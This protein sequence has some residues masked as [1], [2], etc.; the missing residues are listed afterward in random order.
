MNS[1]PVFTNINA[2]DFALMFD[3]AV[4]RAKFVYFDI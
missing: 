1:L 2:T 4:K 3:G